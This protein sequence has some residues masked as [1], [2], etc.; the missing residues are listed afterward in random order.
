MPRKLRS[1]LDSR[2]ARL[3]LPVRGRPY[4]F[5]NVSPG[6]AVGYRRLAGTSGSWVL[7]CADGAGGAWTRRIATADDYESSDGEHVL[8]F[9]QAC[10]RAR[11]MARGTSANAPATWDSA[12]TD[13]AADLRARHGNPANASH[14]RHHLTPALLGR[15]VG[16]LTAIELKRWRNDLLARGIKPATVVRVLKSARASL[17]LAANHDPRIQNRDAWRVGLGG[18]TDTYTPINRVLSD[19][20]VLRLVTA[21]YALDANFGLFVDVLASTGTRTSQACGLL[22]ADLQADRADPRLMM[23]SSRKGKGRKQITRKPVPIPLSLARKLKSDTMSHLAA[24]KRRGDAPLLMR[25]DGT[26]WDPRRQELQTLFAEVA[27]RTGIEAT[28]YSL[29][30]SSIVR[31]LLAG[32]PTRVVASM[33]DTS[34]AILERVY[35]HFILDHADTVARR[36]LL[37]TVQPIAHNVVGLPSKAR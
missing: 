26:A 35:S 32:T 28:A 27:R 5:T 6:T 10:D 8:D 34:T 4:D 16:L 21:A 12:L 15:P 33:H 1:R 19:A 17:N 13:Y 22:V 36:G 25:A 29:R 31:S 11:T 23:P 2:T 30:H 14:V 18:L 24:G 37:D 7:R 20:D 3:D 9:W